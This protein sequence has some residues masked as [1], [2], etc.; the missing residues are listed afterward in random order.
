MMCGS[1]ELVPWSYVTRPGRATEPF[2]LCAPAIFIK[3]RRKLLVRKRGF[4]P[5]RSYERQPLKLVRLPFR[6][7]RVQRES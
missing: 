1:L 3:N 6:H 2:A 4:E 7:F 5:L